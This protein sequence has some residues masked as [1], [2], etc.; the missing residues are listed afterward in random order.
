MTPKSFTIRVYG[1]LIHEGRILLSRENIQGDIYTKFPG[2]GLEFGEGVVDCLKR[3]FREEVAIGISENELF[4]INED[5][6]P[7]AFHRTKQVIVIYYL[8]KSHQSKQIVTGN[9]AD[10]GKLQA[11]GDQVLLWCKLSELNPEKVNLPIDKVVAKKLMKE[12]D[13][14]S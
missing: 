4:Y 6:L 14:L 2:G 5:F 13:S 11:D 3:E 12:L 9:Q 10:A 7:S 8:V 1:L